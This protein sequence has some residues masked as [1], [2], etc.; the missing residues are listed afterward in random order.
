MAVDRAVAKVE[1][2]V[3]AKVVAKDATGEVPSVPEDTVSVL[4][5]VKR[6]LM[7]KELNAP[8]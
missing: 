6:S 5:V 4:N 2:R 3:E 7:R 1:A 8:R